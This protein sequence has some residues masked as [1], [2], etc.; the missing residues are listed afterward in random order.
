MSG[1]VGNHKSE[2]CNR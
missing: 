1:L 2:H